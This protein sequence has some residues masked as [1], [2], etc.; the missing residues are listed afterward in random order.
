M[1]APCALERGPEGDEHGLRQARRRLVEQLQVDAELLVIV[2]AV[3]DPRLLR[4][5]VQCGTPR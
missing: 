4:R 2:E 5:A 1:P 3:A